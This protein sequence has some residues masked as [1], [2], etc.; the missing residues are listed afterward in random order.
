MTKNLLTQTIR[1]KIIET[2]Q[3][4]L[5]KLNRTRKIW[6]VLCVLLTELTRA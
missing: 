3:I 2:K 4:N 6:Y 1:D 5:I